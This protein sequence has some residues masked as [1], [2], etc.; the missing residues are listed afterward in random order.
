MESLK[1]IDIIDHRNKYY[2]QRFV[3]LNR[4][5]VFK[6]ERRGKWLIGEDS[7][8]FNFFY[9]DSP[10]GA[11]YAFGGRKFDIPMVDGTVEKAYGQWWDGV[12]EDYQE[13][14]VHA[15]CGTIEGLG[16]CN[17][18]CSMNVDPD[19]IEKWLSE[20]EPSNNYHKY[21]KRNPDYG[22]HTIISKWEQKT[23]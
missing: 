12:P 4:D 18:F 5:P 21:E 22:K 1:V 20:N 6:Y 2:T 10:G 19:I 15:G 16:K 8:F 17:V 7:G 14:I 9:Y 3:V 23:A 13:L 11:F